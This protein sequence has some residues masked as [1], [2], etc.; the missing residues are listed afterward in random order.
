MFKLMCVGTINGKA[1]TWATHAGDV[2]QRRNGEL[3]IFDSKLKGVMGFRKGA[4]S[5]RER[6]GDYDVYDV[7][8]SQRFQ[9]RR[10]TAP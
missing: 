7:D 10:A 6:T 8:F 5:Q 4:W 9:P 1:R 3:A 2:Q